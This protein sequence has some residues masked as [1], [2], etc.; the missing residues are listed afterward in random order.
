MHGVWLA[1]DVDGAVRLGY[2][3]RAT[4]WTTFGSEFRIFN[5]ARTFQAL[6]IWLAEEGHI[7]GDLA[8]KKLRAS[9]DV[10]VICYQI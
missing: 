2:G 5:G 3:S 9:E 7:I 4:L 10:S 6:L 8:S 1:A